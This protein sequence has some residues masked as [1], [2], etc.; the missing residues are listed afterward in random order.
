MEEIFNLLPGGPIS[1][2]VPGV[3]GDPG[4]PCLPS[5][6]G[7]PVRPMGPILPIDPGLPLILWPGAPGGPDN[8]DATSASCPVKI[9]QY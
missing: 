5:T 6:P 4:G 7:A 2:G 1:P 8:F 3:P 9:I